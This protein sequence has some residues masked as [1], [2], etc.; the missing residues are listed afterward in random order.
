MKP[1]RSTGEVIVRLAHNLSALLLAAAT[2][3]VFF[4]VVTRF[5]LGDAA[6]WSEVLAR[7]LIVWSTLLAAAAGFRLGAMIPIDFLRSL[8]PASLQI[9]VI[10]LVTLL[11]LVFLA[12]LVWQGWAMTLRV[13]AQRVAMLGTSMSLFYAAI[14][15]G[16]MAA[17]AGVILHHLDQERQQP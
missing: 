8:L 4:Q 5:V 16:A 11:T 14:P 6:G 1:I 2:A 12:I 3:L 17:I 10:R 13:Q 9:W 7:G 15:A